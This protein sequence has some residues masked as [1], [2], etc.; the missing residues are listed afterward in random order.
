MYKMLKYP[1]LFAVLITLAFS[2]QPNNTDTEA[3]AFDKAMAKAAIEAANLK[4][5]DAYSKGDPVAV[6]ACYTSDAKFMEPNKPTL[7]G[8]AAILQGVTASMA[9]G[10]SDLNLNITEV[11]GDEDMIVEEGTYAIGNGEITFDTGKYIVLWKKED[12]VW[13]LHRDI[14][15]SDNPL[16]GQAAVE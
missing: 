15:N 6:A 3:P 1:L 14:Y 13:K 5:S 11:W 2:C 10:V 9:A 8:R 4:M 16:P 7:V 12:G